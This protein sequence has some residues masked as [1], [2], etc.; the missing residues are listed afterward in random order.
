MRNFLLFLEKCV[1]PSIEFMIV[2][3]KID[4]LCVSETWLLPNINNELI[5]ISEFR[6]FRRD[7]GRGGGVCIYVRSD[8]QARELFTNNP[9]NI[10][11]E[12][13][14]LVVQYRKFPSFIVGVVYRHP[15]A[16]NASF[17]YL[18]EIFP[19]MA[20]KNKPLEHKLLSYS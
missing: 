2:E 4:I 12:D 7:R 11:V 15:H 9:N 8:F 13:V 18:A 5:D 19:T 16:Q 3:R 17:D 14:W 20:L 6:V 10:E 1:F